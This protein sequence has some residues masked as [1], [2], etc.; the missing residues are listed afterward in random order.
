MGENTTACIEDDKASMHQREDARDNTKG[1][2]K[3]GYKSRPGTSVGMP[4]TIQEGKRKCGDKSGPC[5]LRG[6]PETIQK[7]RKKG[8]YKSIPGA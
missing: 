5:T 3:N 1:K 7:E 4:D 6:M 2:R 8:G